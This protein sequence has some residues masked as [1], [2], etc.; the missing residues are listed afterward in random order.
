MSLLLTILITLTIPIVNRLIGNEDLLSW[1]KPRRII[2]YSL[3][4]VL[5]TALAY[6][7]G[8]SLPKLIYILCAVSIGYAIYRQPGPDI[9]FSAIH[10]RQIAVPDP[11]WIVWMITKVHKINRFRFGIGSP[12]TLVKLGVIGGTY[13]GLLIIPL[14]L[15]M[16][17]IW[18]YAILLSILGLLF[19][20]IYKASGIFGFFKFEQ[21]SVM[22]A[23][24]I[25]GLVIVVPSIVVPILMGK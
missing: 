24:L 6:S 3:S 19:G 16:T 23:E 14:T 12:A 4:G 21:G 25:T 18:K 15:L 8:Y 17:F 5:A 1:L 11:A 22:R 9:A 2:L 7:C 20:L 10:G 13:R